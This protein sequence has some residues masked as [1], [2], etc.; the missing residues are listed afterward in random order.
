MSCVNGT[1][2]KKHESDIGLNALVCCVIFEGIVDEYFGHCDPCDQD[3][4]DE[5]KHLEDI[6]VVFFRVKYWECVFGQ[7][8][9]Y[10]EK[11]E[12]EGKDVCRLVGGQVDSPYAEELKA[13][14]IVGNGILF[15]ETDF[16]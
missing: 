5:W 12:D 16:L 14:K 2:K 10:V 11:S 1:R 6:F 13:G 15:N 4:A 7:K 8:P 9:A 3:A